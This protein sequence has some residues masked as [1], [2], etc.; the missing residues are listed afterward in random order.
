MGSNAIP[1]SLLQLFQFGKPVL[2][3]PRKH[4]LFVYSDL[5]D[6]TSAG[7]QRH[8]T[9]FLSKVVSISWAIQAAR[10]SQ[11]HCV[12]YWISIRGLT[13]LEPWI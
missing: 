1:H 8:F 11:R 3:L 7:K 9:H 12:Q 10:I 2:L 6:A 13:I 5:K 4:H